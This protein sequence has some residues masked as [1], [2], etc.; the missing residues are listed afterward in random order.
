MCIANFLDWQ[1]FCVQ[2]WSAKLD[3]FF[4]FMIP[5]RDADVHYG[6]KWWLFKGQL[7][8]CPCIFLL[9]RFGTSTGD[10]TNLSSFDMISNVVRFHVLVALGTA[11]V[12]LSSTLL[13]CAKS[14]QG[15]TTINKD[16]ERRGKCINKF[17]LKVNLTLLEQFPSSLLPVQHRVL[18]Q[19]PLPERCPKVCLIMG[20][21]FSG[22]LTFWNPQKWNLLH[23]SGVHWKE[24]KALWELR[25]RVGHP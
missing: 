5:L 11:S 25:S 9:S 10:G 3:H 16:E 13:L 19:R 18:Q 22:K 1:Y 6:R 12:L 23:L 20:Q 8:S 2:K 4:N 15:T 24:G 21:V 17:A 14:S 7:H